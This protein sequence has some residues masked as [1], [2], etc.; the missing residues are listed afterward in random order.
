MNFIARLPVGPLLVAG[1][2][3]GLAPFVPQPHLVEKLRMLFAGN[4]ERPLDIFDL[5]F[6]LSPF[7]LL[8]LKGLA[9]GRKAP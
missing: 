8:L 7:L 1:I 9:M 5:F 4:L 3:L 6:H 2:F